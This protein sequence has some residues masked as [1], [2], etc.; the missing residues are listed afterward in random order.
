MYIYICIEHSLKVPQKKYRHL[1]LE[2]F[3]AACEAQT[4]RLRQQI[5]EERGEFPQRKWDG[6]GDPMGYRGHMG[7]LLLTSGWNG[8]SYF[9]IDQWME[10]GKLFCY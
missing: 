6:G 7:Q 1:P 8:V 10:W 9:V 4:D 3:N 2:D 5:N